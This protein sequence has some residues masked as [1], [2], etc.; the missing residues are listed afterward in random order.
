MAAG[1]QSQL[2]PDA[3]KFHVGNGDDGKHYWITPPEV[4]EPLQREF[5]FDFDPCPHP[6]PESF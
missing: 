3:N 6:K 2:Q 4:M 1:H 5:A